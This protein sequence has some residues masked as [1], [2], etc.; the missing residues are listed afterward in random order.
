MTDYQLY[1]YIFHYDSSKC[2]LILSDI[3]WY[4]CRLDVEGL[5]DDDDLVSALGTGRILIRLR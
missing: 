3:S 1:I 2:W 5:S 4:D